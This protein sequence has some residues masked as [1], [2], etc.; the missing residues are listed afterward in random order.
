MVLWLLA[1]AL[2]FIG[3]EVGIRYVP[4]DAIQV[5]E[6]SVASGHLLRTREITDS[7]LVADFH[8]R[9]NS[10]PSATGTFHCPLYDPKTVTRYTVRFTRWRLPVEVATVTQFGCQ[11]WSLG[12]GGFTEAVPR[13]D[14][15]GAMQP[16]IQLP[17]P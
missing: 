14:P 5:S 13:Y 6:F 12:S 15:N 3:F 1:A 11:F 4:P 17:Q 9:L 8:D 16:L 10:L 7:H 2:L